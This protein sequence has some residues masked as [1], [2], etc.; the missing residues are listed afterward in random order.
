MTNHTLGPWKV[1]H[2][3]L[4]PQFKTKII[5]IQ[6]QGG[7]AIIAW[8]GFDSCDLP[9][10]VKLANARRIVACVNACA[11]INPEAVPDLVAKLEKVAV[12]LDRLTA[13]NKQL[14]A[15]TDYITLK[16]ACEADAKNFGA[17]AKDIRAALAKAKLP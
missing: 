7:E 13:H 8:P 1:Y 14:A 10:G 12:W 3:R 16:E 15:K 9:K 17:T 5:E 2:K 6:R 4:R 11:G